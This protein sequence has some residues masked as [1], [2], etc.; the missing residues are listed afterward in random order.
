MERGLL[1]VRQGKGRKDRVVPLSTVALEA[2]RLYRRYRP[3]PDPWLFPGQRRGRHLSERSVQH[4]FAK[5]RDRAGIT[6]PATVHTLRHSFAT[7]LHE[8]GIGLR[9]I[10]SLL[11]HRSSRTTEIYTHV[12]RADLANIQSPLDTLMGPD[13]PRAADDDPE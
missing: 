13:A 9:Y 3:T 6:K 12:S 5:A 4:V 7:H 1:H 10:Q 8:A 2:L 11:G